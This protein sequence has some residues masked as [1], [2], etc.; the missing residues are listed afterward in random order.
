M[1]ISRGALPVILMAA[2][3]LCL[4]GWAQARDCAGKPGAPVTISATVT[5]T[6]AR[7]KVTSNQPATGLSVRF[8][9]T[10]GLSVRGNAT[11]VSGRACTTGEILPLEVDFTPGRGYCLLVV[12]VKGTFDGRPSARVV[13]FA[14]GT[15]QARQKSAGTG[16]GAPGG[17]VQELPGTTVRYRRLI[18]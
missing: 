18:P 10:D 13:S 11:P 15:P 3:T 4:S 5:G 16:K 12:T 8:H 7:V 9:G 17:S 1:R 6:T 14:V 2:L